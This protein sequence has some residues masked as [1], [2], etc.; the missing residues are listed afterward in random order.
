MIK[1]TLK[2]IFE[3]LFKVENKILK[4]KKINQVTKKINFQIK[5]IF[6]LKFFF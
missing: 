3:K 4:I 6:T 2:P 1:K 5:K